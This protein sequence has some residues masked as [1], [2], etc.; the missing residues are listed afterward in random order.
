M[1]VLKKA[2]DPVVT[3]QIR[4]VRRGDVVLKIYGNKFV[5]DSRDRRELETVR[6]LGLRPAI[7]AKDRD[8]DLTESFGWDW[9]L[10]GTRP[11]GGGRLLAPLNRVVSLGTWARA[12]RRIR[13]AVISGH[14]LLGTFI[15]WL[16]TCFMSRS[17]RPVLV[18][19]AHEYTMALYSG[20]RRRLVVAVEGFLMR[21]CAFAIVVNDSIAD[22]MFK[23][24]KSVKR[25]LVVR[26]MTDRWDVDP[27]AAQGHRAEY[28]STLGLPSDT[29]VMMYHGMVFARRGIEAVIR[30]LPGRDRVA[31]VI[32][33][34]GDPMYIET[35][36]SL[37]AELGVAERLLLLPAVE[38]G[39]LGEHVAA[40]DVGMM[41]VPPTHD[42]EYLMLP[43]KF[44]ENIQAQTPV[45][46]SDFP[47]IAALIN[48]YDIGLLVDPLNVDQIGDAIDSLVE[49]ADLRLRFER[50]LARAK[51][52]LCWENEQHRLADAYRELMARKI[53]S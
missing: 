53:L 31:L 42:S 4:A 40:A 11:L 49:S 2:G 23:A 7:L 21:R 14:D 1:R 5:Q 45:I 17:G 51:V 26:S 22:G 20:W 47:E 28:L 16:S 29:F 34:D 10:A 44:F 6:Q 18:Y 39:V 48:E 38:F 50:N 43:N 36:Q 33:G 19:D 37:A 27:A 46:A 30:A 3:R 12:A 35:L 13:P 15:G 25:P 24:H 52:E 32:L 41:T 8:V 9:H